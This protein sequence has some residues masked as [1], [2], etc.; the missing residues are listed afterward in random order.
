MLLSIPVVLHHS[1]LPKFKYWLKLWH[2]KSRHFFKSSK[3]AMQLKIFPVTLHVHMEIYWVSPDSSWAIHTGVGWVWLMRLVELLFSNFPPSL[4]QRPSCHP[5]CL[6]YEMERKS[7]EHK[8]D[9]NVYRSSHKWCNVYRSRKVSFTVAVF[10]LDN[11]WR[12][13]AFQKY[14]SFQSLNK[15]YL[16]SIETFQTR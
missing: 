5:V 12:L 14:P 3:R 6:W 4:V 1:R 7:V 2:C 13:F 15:G 10:F 11:E 16:C 9:I 8:K